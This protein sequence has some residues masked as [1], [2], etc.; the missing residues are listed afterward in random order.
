MKLFVLFVILGSSALSY[1]QSE[2]EIVSKYRDA[3]H[4]VAD[5]K[6]VQSM[7][8]KGTFT[9]QKLSFPAAIYYRAPSIRVEMSFQSLTFL[10]ISNDS[11]RWEYNP[12]EEKNTITPLTNKEGDWA[13][14]SNSFDFINYDLLNYK[15]LKHKL[16]IVGK[17]KVDSLDVYVLELSKSDK[18][19]VKFLINSKN[20]LIYKIE[21]VKG[22][23]YFA[24]YSNQN[25]YVFPRYILE[26]GQKRDL[27]AHFS[28][29]NFNVSLPDSLF[30]IPTDALAGKNEKVKHVR[31]NAMSIGDS[32]YSSGEYRQAVAQY[33]TVIKSQPENEFAY[34]ARGLA[35][36]ALKEYYE[37]IAD[38]NRAAEI[39]PKSA[40]PQNNLGLAKYYLGDRNGALKDYDKAL[41]LDPKLAVAY[42]NRGI[43]YLE[44][45]KN[46][47]AANDFSTVTKLDSTNGLAYFRLGV[48]LA[49]QEKFEEA[50]QSYASAK[51]NKYNSADVHNY[52][53]VSEYRLERY[54]S[55]TESFKRALSREPMHLQYIENY[56]RALY[57][58][59]N[60]AAA[61]EQFEKYIKEKDDNASI[62]NLRGLCKYNEE[63]YSGAIDDFSKSIK[64]NE[65]EAT[66]YDNRASA[67]EMLEDYEGAIKDYGESIRVY[68]NDPSVFYRRGMVKINTSKKLEGCMDLATAN[69]MKY[70][71]ANEA[72]I[73]NCH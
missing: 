53:G 69:E 11:I 57:E 35:K 70:Q 48:A 34:N 33:T 13:A 37:A 28:Q 51:R 1:S 17:E 19:T 10:Q 55:A 25:G 72:I 58:M 5:E 71:P 36:L 16:K 56:G 38:F 40:N 32:L 64:L 20:G 68:P 31:P 45:D 8:L 23:R 47:L 49:E 9:S 41:E 18:T 46:Q 52:Q 21:D 27:E 65:K 66:Y 24:N 73:S 54:D 61:S 15:Q 4:K 59:G 43:I 67:K 6:S 7:A 3:L 50:L 42:N 30:V 2:K 44:S 39:N 62:Y 22:Y 14:G 29:L 63:D 60:F 12:M 26:S